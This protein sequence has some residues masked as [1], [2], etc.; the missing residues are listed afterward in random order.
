MEFLLNISC[1]WSQKIPNWRN[2]VFSAW[3]EIMQIYHPVRE[4][5][6]HT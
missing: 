2:V 6:A 3:T 1:A 5:L 4:E